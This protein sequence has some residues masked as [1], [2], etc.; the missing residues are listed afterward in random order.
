MSGLGI[1]TLV[2]TSLAFGMS[3]EEWKTVALRTKH[4]FLFVCGMVMS[5]LPGR[6][7]EDNDDDESEWMQRGASLLDRIINPPAENVVQLRAAE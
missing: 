2:M 5:L 3:W 7:D 1:V 6:G 4:A